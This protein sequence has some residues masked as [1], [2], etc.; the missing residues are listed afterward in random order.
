MANELGYKYKLDWSGTATAAIPA[1]SA[2]VI[3]FSAG[4]ISLPASQGAIAD[5]FVLTAIASGEQGQVI[6]DGI[7]PVKIGTASGVAKGDLLTPDNATGAVS[8][9]AT[10]D[11]ACAQ[12]LQAPAANGDLILARILTNKI[13]I[14]A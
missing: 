11:V 2:V 3:D 8:E 6:L 7:V 9:A 12:A 5:G 13:T 1:Y 14:P 10:A 4:T